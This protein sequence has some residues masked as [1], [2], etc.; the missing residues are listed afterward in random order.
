MR[1]NLVPPANRTGQ[2]RPLFPQKQLRLKK[3]LSARSCLSVISP[4]AA[5]AG[6][7]RHTRKCRLMLLG[8]PPDMV[9]GHAL[10]GTGR[11]CHRADETEK[12]L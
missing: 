11:D 3:R 12:G 4:M 1:G 6:W 10:R 2:R 9:H 8:S 7:P 5:P